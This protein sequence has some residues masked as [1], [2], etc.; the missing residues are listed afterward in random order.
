M[1]GEK[2][3]AGAPSRPVLLPSREAQWATAAGIS[4]SANPRSGKKDCKVVRGS[5]V[6]LAQ[7]PRLGLENLGRVRLLGRRAS[8]TM[9]GVMAVTK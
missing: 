1:C 9:V 3:W 7:K 8:R 6:S 4:E 2:K 5:L